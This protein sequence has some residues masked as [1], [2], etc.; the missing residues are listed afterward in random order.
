MSLCQTL[1][2]FDTW[3]STIP[4]DLFMLN[5]LIMNLVTR[6]NCSVVEYENRI[7]CFIVF[8]SEQTNF[9]TICSQG[10]SVI[11]AAMLIKPIGR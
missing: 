7:V 11:F 8:F 9:D 1:G 10:F 4:V 3:S 6:N 2:A 5:P